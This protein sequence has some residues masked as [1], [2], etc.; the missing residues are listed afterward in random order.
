MIDKMSSL[1][2]EEAIFLDKARSHLLNSPVCPVFNPKL[3]CSRRGSC[4][5]VMHSLYSSEE[6][7]CSLQ[8]SLA[9]S[10]AKLNQGEGEVQQLRFFD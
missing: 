7:T 10:I 5:F 4:E 8:S 3:L 1:S 9:L 2:S 6:F